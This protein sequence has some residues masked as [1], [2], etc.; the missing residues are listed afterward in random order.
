MKKRKN[1]FLLGIYVLVV[2]INVLS[3]YSSG[4][5]DGIRQSVFY[6]TQ[7]IQGHFSSLFPFS[8]GEFLLI[9]AVVMAALA[10]VLSVIVSIKWTGGILTG[11]KGMAGGNSGREAVCEEKARIV[12]FAGRYFYCLL[13]IIGIVSAVMST[14]CFVLYHCSSFQENYM[15]GRGREYHIRELALVR[16]HIVRQCNELAETMERDENGY[17]VYREDIG[18]RAVSEMKRLGEEY[19]LL[20]GYYPVPKKFM[21]SGFF[22][23]QYIMGYYFPFSMEANYNGT[24]YIANVP[25]TICHELS[26]VKGFIYE[27]DANFIGFLACISSDDAFF[28][29]SGYLSALDYLNRDLYESLGRSREAYLS[30]EV[31]SPLVERDNIFLTSQAW[32][33]VESRAVINTEIVKQASRSFLETNLQVNGVGEGIASYGDVVERLLIYYDGELY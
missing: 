28:R 10:F 11:R 24:M 20:D 5:G 27:D 33:E 21:F 14:N 31:C 7:Y 18:Q 6:V 19:P 13:W 22:S 16:D 1:W 2:I 4:F 15:P 26:H 12:R 9:F 30:Y 17:I 32:E 8:I 3:W 29:Y 23:Q 25:P